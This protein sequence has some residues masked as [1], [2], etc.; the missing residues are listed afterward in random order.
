GGAGMGIA[1]ANAGSPLGNV[2]VAATPRGLCFVTLGDSERAVESALAREFPA[3]PRVRDDS[4][5]SKY[6]KDVLS[7]IAGREPHEQLAFDLRA[8]AFQR[9]VWDALRKIPA[10]ST[11]S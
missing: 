4:A 10:G 2:L 8:T 9:Q 1:Y 6:V 3:A 7:R 5:L 11:V